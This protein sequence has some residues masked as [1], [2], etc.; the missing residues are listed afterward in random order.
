MPRHSRHWHLFVQG[1]LLGFA[2]M[3]A[4]GR[5]RTSAERHRKIVMTLNIKQQSTKVS[6]TGQITLED[7]TQIRASGF[8]T[9]IINRPDA[10]AGGL[11][12]QS[13]SLRRAAA[14]HGMTVVYLPVVP[15]EISDEQV[16]AFAEAVTA[17]PGPVLAYCAS[18]KRASTL[19]ARSALG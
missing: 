16:K 2:E 14:D 10:E 6:T 1:A 3:P 4:F 15:N 12:A 18:G 7:L 11:H 13:E 5:R 19:V 17:S 9:I 8:L